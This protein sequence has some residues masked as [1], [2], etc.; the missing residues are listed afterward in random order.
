MLSKG[1]QPF[2]KCRAEMIKD[3]L[4][5]KLGENVNNITLKSEG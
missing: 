2:G 3:L 1:M 5:K 4:E